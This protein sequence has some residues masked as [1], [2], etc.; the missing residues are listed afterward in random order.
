MTSIKNI[1]SEIRRLADELDYQVYPPVVFPTSLYTYDFGRKIAI[2][3]ESFWLQY[4]AFVELADGFHIDGYYL[5]GINNHADY[6]NDLFTFNGFLTNIANEMPS[7]MIEDDFYCIEFGVSSLDT[8]TYD[9]RTNKW[10]SRDRQ[11]HQ[12]LFIS[13]DTL[14]E[15]LQAVIDE[16]RQQEE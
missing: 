8:F 3:P 14:A 4:K 16:I 10:E 5:Y 6:K 7:M 13:C 2:A 1:I 11:Q 12:N 9:V 15:F